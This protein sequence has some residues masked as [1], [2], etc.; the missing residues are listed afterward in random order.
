MRV[1]TK[2]NAEDVQI[3]AMERKRP[4]DERELVQRYKV[5]AKLQTAQDFEILVEGLICEPNHSA[6]LA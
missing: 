2:A 5:F 6:Q 1:A 4:K 3:Q